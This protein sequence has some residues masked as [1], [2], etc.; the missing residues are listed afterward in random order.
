MKKRLQFETV[1]RAI[2]DVGGLLRHRSQ[3]KFSFVSPWLRGTPQWWSDHHSLRECL[4]WAEAIRTEF[5]LPTNL[6]AQRLKREN[7]GRR[8]EGAASKVARHD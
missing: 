7:H 5:G 6:I 8:R 3:R 1:S 4:E 2:S